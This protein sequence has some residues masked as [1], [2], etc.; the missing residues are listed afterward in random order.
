MQIKPLDD[1]VLVKPSDPEEKTASG[2]YLPQGAK[3][4]PQQGTVV[5]TGPGRLLKDGKRSPIAVKKGE[6]VV[7]GKYSG[8]EIEIKGVKH[9]IL[10]ESD[11][12]GVIEK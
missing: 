7:Y 12:L 3:E 9:V 2:L 11:L 4:K 5:A 1:R 8:S 6:T 10:E